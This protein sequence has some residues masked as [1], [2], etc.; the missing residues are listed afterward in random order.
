MK[1][2]ASGLCQTVY[3][4][5]NRAIY[6]NF[7]TADVQAKEYRQKVTGNTSAWS[8]ISGLDGSILASYRGHPTLETFLKVFIDKRRILAL[9]LLDKDKGIIKDPSYYMSL[10]LGSGSTMEIFEQG[11]MQQQPQQP[12]QPQPKS[13]KSN[14]HSL[15]PFSSTGSTTGFPASDNKASPRSA[16]GSKA[17]VPM[18]P[19]SL[20]G[21]SIRASVVYRMLLVPEDESEGWEIG[22]CTSKGHLLKIHW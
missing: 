12:Q 8:K 21:A 11:G 18:L 19:S 15:R 6:A 4:I 17:F 5:T 22:A 10:H 16:G 1:R 20:T 7:V 2:H 14:V 13:G 9:D 3:C